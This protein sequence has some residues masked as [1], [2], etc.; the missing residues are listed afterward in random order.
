MRPRKI[1]IPPHIRRGIR[2]RKSGFP[3]RVRIFGGD[4]ETVEG[5]PLTLQLADSA[6][7]AEVLWINE[8]T[9]WREFI[10]WVEPRL[11]RKHV[12]VCYF[13]N[14]AF[15]LTALLYQYKD[16][17]VNGT[18]VK[19]T[20]EG[21]EVSVL[22]GKIWYA[23]IDF[24]GTP[25]HLIDSFR[26]YTTSLKKIAKTL[27]CQNQK[28]DPPEGLGKVRFT[29]K[30]RHFVDYARNDALVQWEVG[31]AIV[32]M[33]EE[34][35][36]PISISAPQFAM[37]VFCKHHLKEEEAIRLPSDRIL[38]ASIH[39]YHGGK[40]G[41]YCK[42]GL[43]KD[44]KE[45]D[46]SSAY[47]AAMKALP[48]FLAGSYQHTRIVR[49]DVVGVYMIRGKVG[50]CR[51]P[52]FLTHD[53]Q[54]IYGES[55]V[56][57]LWVTCY[58]LWE[59]LDRGEVELETVS[60]WVWVPEEGARNPLSSFV[61]EYYAKKEATPKTDPRYQTYKLLLNSCY[62][63]FIQNI[64]QEPEADV[65][66]TDGEV[67]KV[68]V[69][70]KAGGMFHPFIASLITGYVRAYLHRMEH[71]FQAI[72]SSTDSIKT[73]L[74]VKQEDL[75]RGLGGLNVE[76]AGDCVVLRNKLY[77]HWAG[78]REGMPKKYALHGFW[79]SVGDLVRVLDTRNNVY[80][81]EHI[82][83]LRE[84][85]RQ[86]KK[87][88]ASYIQK[89][90]VE[91]GWEAWIGEVRAAGGVEEEAWRGEIP[92]PAGVVAQGVRRGAT[93]GGQAKGSHEGKRGTRSVL[94]V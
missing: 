3:G 76:I 45:I 35:D 85:H 73:I 69:T 14:L 51:Y 46:I 83:R 63:K 50:R 91:I 49:R 67:R 78:E 74:P 29:K 8:A 33:H 37:R 86:K 28:L 47:P 70:Y 56:S 20:I 40:N 53:G 39:S 41:Y 93:G 82:F 12:N 30:D 75:P 26:F 87:A 68:P 31:R 21:R 17:L 27:N 88:L 55:K 72:H 13:H 23:K 65:E 18:D 92:A 84:A 38:S 19:M 54:P 94:T 2:H 57:G 32:D 34:Y 61:D 44:C 24:D 71:D 11:W 15:D 5:E 16:K 22:C 7:T 80:E 77:L 6:K 25:L 36:V 79:G 52:I 66:V 60:G 42:P 89:R 64:E 58:E 10:K 43:Y 62:G 48:S 59:A 81:V 9:I 90:E 1:V 4:V